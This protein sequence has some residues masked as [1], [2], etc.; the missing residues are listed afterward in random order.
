ME[1]Y[2]AVLK[3]YGETETEKA[4]SAAGKYLIEFDDEDI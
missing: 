4:Y 1:V 2:Y 3:E